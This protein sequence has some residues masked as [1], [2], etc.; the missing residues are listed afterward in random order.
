MATRKSIA[1][2]PRK[3]TTDEA[4]D[5]AKQAD[6]TVQQAAGAAGTG[7][8][9][10]RAASSQSPSADGSSAATNLAHRGL[11]AGAPDPV[12]DAVDAAGESPAVAAIGAAPAVASALVPAETS[13][14]AAQASSALSSPVADVVAGA[15][16]G[17]KASSALGQAVA[18]L[19]G[20]EPPIQP[21]RYEFAIV[22][23]PDIPLR[24]RR[25][26]LTEALSQPYE[27]L[28][29]LV[30]DD[31]E[32]PTDELEGARA[33]L[34]IDR[35]EPMRSIYGI[36]D[37][38]EY[39]GV[40]HQ[41]LHLRVRVVPAFRLLEHEV[42]TRIFQGL[43]VKEILSKVLTASLTPYERK[44][45]AASL[46]KGTYD[47]RDYCTQF[48]ESNFDFCCRLMEEEGIGY[49]FAFDEGIQSERLVLIDNNNDYGKPTLVKDD[50]IPIILDRPDHADC[51]SI[52]ALRWKLERRTSKVSTRGYNEKVPRSVDGAIAEG[53]DAHH[54]TVREVYLHDERRQIIEDV[55]GDP[56]ADSYTGEDLD[57]R[58]PLALRTFQRFRSE[59][60]F[61]EGTSN[62]TDLR[63]GVVIKI[64]QHPRADIDGQ[65]FL[66]VAADHRG[67]AAEVDAVAERVEDQ[68][69]NTFSCIPIAH[70]FRPPHRRKKPEILVAQSGRVV[71]P[72]GEEIHCDKFGRIKVRFHWDRRPEADEDSSCW[73]RVVQPWS[74]PSWGFVFIPRIGM[75]VLIQFLDGN[76][77]R[78]VVTGSLYNGDN[79]PPYTLP[80]EKTKSVIKTS[81]SPGGDGYNELTFEDAAGAEQI[82]VHAQKDFNETVEHD[83][84]T[85]VHHDQTIAVDVNQSTSV[86]GDQS[87]TVTG[88]Q[89][90]TVKQ[91]VT[92]TVEGTRTHT[93]TKKET[94]TLRDALELTVGT[95]EFHQVTD[96]LTEQFDKGRQTTVQQGD[97]ETVST[98]DK[99]VTV[100]DGALEAYA[101]NKLEVKQKTHSMLLQDKI[102]VSTSTDFSI[103]N[104][105]TTIESTGGKLQIT[106]SEELSL[107][108]G[109]G[110]IV[111]KS[112][113]TIDIQGARKVTVGTPGSSTA[114]EP[115]GVTTNGAKIST[116]AIGIHEL[117]GAMVKLN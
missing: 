93:I 16:G 68:Y 1:M 59:T 111:I 64:G 65:R 86:G 92:I 108:C 60:K 23:G 73:M 51:E 9:L 42:D 62:V 20:A 69:S 50:E 36:V 58:E 35:R 19:S 27:L 2:D 72:A 84:T 48:R 90:E 30:C 116:S 17:G 52:Q 38:V 11:Q 75:E 47:K 82:I 15:I 81:S 40:T 26:K 79:M 31:P 45:D 41:R 29:D 85:I 39:L 18:V 32:A 112:D 115:A 13:G 109:A 4:L 105:K 66:V 89:T 25:V 5:V 10:A 114:L 99:K 8:D 44:F 67:D 94:V 101:S 34:L 49:F 104:G 37:L 12:L 6:A 61:L 77:D 55:D 28:V 117:K 78:P 100:S 7:I 88:H 57:Q 87:N 54:P 95:T 24:V 46:L 56:M 97:T 80:D 63:P 83:H 110:S 71:G 102:E 33:E 21:V 98:G 91:N 74:G 53:S 103:T 43:D 22:G 70:E 76:P 96:K 113:G 107:T 3:P 106:A 14:V